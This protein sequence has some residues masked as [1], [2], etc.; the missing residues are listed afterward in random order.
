[1]SKKILAAQN[2]PKKD[3]ERWKQHDGFMVSRVATIEK[4]R[5]NPR[6]RENLFKTGDALLVQCN[7]YDSLWSVGMGIKDFQA[8]VEDHK[9][10]KITVPGQIS[11]SGLKNVPEIGKGKN[12]LGMMIMHTRDQLRVE[13]GRSSKPTDAPKL[14]SEKKEQNGEVQ[15]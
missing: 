1:M 9:G 6:L 14:T 3:V 4:F 15:E 13:F 8:W 10:D 5:Q 11:Q 12:I 7:Q 2:V